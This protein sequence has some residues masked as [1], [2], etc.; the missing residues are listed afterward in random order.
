MLRTV[1]RIALL[2]VL[3]PIGCAGPPSGSSS[4]PAVMS[5]REQTETFYDLNVQRV[6]RIL[7]PAMRANGIDCWIIM[8]REGFIDPVLEYIR[9]ENGEGGHRNAF[10]FFDDGSDRLR[11]IVIGTHL[12][13]E[14]QVFDDVLGYGS[15]YGPSGPSLQPELRRIVHELQPERIGVNQSRTIGT[16]DGLTVEMKQ[17]LVEAIGPTYAQRLV[18]AE[19]LVFDFLDT[20]LPEER[21][22]FEEAARITQQ[23]HEEVLSDLVIEPGVTRVSDVQWYTY[24]RMHELGVV[25]GYPVTLS[26]MREGGRVRDLD[27]VIQGGDLIKTD[28]G[29]IY[30][31]LY[32]DFKRTAYVLKPGETEAPAGLQRAMDNAL[33][34]QDVVAEVALSGVLGYEVKDEAEARLAQEG[35]EASV[36][37]HSVAG[38]IHGVGSWFGANWPDRY[39]VRTTFPVRDGAFYALESSATT[40]VPEWGDIPLSFGTEESVYAT[41]DGL[42]SFIPRQETLYL[43]PSG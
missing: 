37:S 20:T 30:V 17:H 5:L 38:F 4:A 22:L 34:V 24:N 19:P 16:A 43:I 39:S 7:L 3:L 9:D 14:T 11:R 31:G 10:I 33:R 13:Q 40:P 1:P 35:I 27:P 15:D 8:S 25:P 6:D 23:I 18:S 32:T 26:V 36:A 2:L 28:I 12:P 29:I 21:V 41:P 42:E